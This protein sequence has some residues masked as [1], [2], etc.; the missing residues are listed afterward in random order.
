MG[1]YGLVVTLSWLGRI[2]PG[3]HRIETPV[4]IVTTEL[5]DDGTV[6]VQNVP[7]YRLHTGVDT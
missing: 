3:T 4:G 6:T 2:R 5:H 7:S 1:E